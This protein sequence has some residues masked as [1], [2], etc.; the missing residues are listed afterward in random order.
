M[1][2]QSLINIFYIVEDGTMREAKTK[3]IDGILFSVTPFP[4]TEAF[5]LKA[6]LFKKFAPAAG[7]LT[8]IMKDG[9]PQNGKVGDIKIDPQVV[10]QTI[11]KL[12]S[13]LGEDD[14][15]GLIKR[16]LKNVG[17]KLTVEGTSLELYFTDKTF[18]AS[19]DIVFGGKTFSLYP[20]LLFVLE[21]NYP[22]FFGMV[23][24]NIG[25]KI[26]AMVT[27]GSPEKG[28]KRK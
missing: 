18:D 17:A 10:S 12:V 22:D 15:I 3:E 9:L 23:A 4:A 16:L 5:K 7:E 25:G 8:G 19:L 28:S 14:F 24:G 6:Y 21:A 27:S 13:Q 11:E 26:K 1:G 20:V 2:E